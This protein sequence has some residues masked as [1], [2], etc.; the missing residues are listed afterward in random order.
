[1]RSSG[2]AST[3]GFTALP[4]RRSFTLRSK[5]GKPVRPDREFMTE[6]NCAL[7]V[8]NWWRDEV[9]AG[10]AEYPPPQPNATPPKTCERRGDRGRLYPAHYVKGEAEDACCFECHEFAALKDHL[11]FLR[12]H[13]RVTDGRAAPDEEVLAEAAPPPEPYV[14]PTAVA[15]AELAARGI[16]LIETKLE[17]EDPKAL[18]RMVDRYTKAAGKRRG[19]IVV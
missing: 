15:C 12:V 17:T 6:L 7:P 16:I 18:Q 14:S 11:Q 10:R 1:M 13:D 19:R 9:L 4:A 8:G 3:R 2:V 5:R